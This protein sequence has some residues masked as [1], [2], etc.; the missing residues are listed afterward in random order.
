M[1]DVDMG[2]EK[3]DIGWP[4]VPDGLYQVLRY[5]KDRYGNTPIY[6]TENGAC[7]NDEPVDGTVRD[8]RRIEYLKRHL[9]QVHRAL[10]DGVNLKGYMA[11][12]L[13]DNFEWAEG[14]SKRFGLVHVD[15][16]S[17]KRT[18]KE[19][20]HWYQKVVWNGWLES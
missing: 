1:E 17:L 11:W 4:I 13:L 14:Y 3:T 12:S 18:R 19:S 16:R 8:F 6:I 15:F 10:E 5:L 9:I 7:Y 2:Y 20:F